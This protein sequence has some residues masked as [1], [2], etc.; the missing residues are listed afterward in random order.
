LR[1]NNINPLV[2]LFRV[3]QVVLQPEA[4]REFIGF[5]TEHVQVEKILTY[6]AIKYRRQEH[7]IRREIDEIYYYDLT[8]EDRASLDS[9]L[10]IGEERGKRATIL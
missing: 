8:S 5:D 9:K 2:W 3:N 7:S 4:Q 1:I 6:V 10:K